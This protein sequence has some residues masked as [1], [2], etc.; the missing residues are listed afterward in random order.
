V[1]GTIA[2]IAVYVGFLVI[3]RKYVRKDVLTEDE[4]NA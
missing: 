2:G 3:G 1:G 4:Q